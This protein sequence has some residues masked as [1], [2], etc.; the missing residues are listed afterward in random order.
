VLATITRF[1]AEE[2]CGQ[3]TPCREGTSW[4]N[5]ILWR[6]LE[7]KATPAEIELIENLCNNMMGRT[8]CVLA[9]AMVMPVRSFL[10]K[11]QGEFEAYFEQQKGDASTRIKVNTG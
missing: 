7:H 5:D 9:D 4:V 8:I 2:S 11:F 3:C 10:Q 6:L 1:Y